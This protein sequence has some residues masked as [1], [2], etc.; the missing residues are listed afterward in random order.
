MICAEK[1]RL[2][3]EYSTAVKNLSAALD[4][5][6]SQTGQEEAKALAASKAALAECAKARRALADHKAQHGC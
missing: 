2:R 3:D 4:N 6:G 1:D 5:L